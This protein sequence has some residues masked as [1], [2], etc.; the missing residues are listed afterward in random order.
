[1]KSFSLQATHIVAQKLSRSEKM[2]GSIASG[3]WVLHP[4]FMRACADAGEVIDERAFEWGAPDNGFVDKDRMSE[5]EL[6]LARASHRWRK[7]V[8]S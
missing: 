2:L 7:Q 6:G 4:L 5:L 3:K 1:M 8:F